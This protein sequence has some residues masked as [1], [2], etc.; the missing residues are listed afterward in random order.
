MSVQTEITRINNEVTGQADLIAQIQTALE[1]KAAGGGMET[2]TITI[3]YTSSSS[4]STR[5]IA[6]LEDGTMYYG[7]E[8]VSANEEVCLTVPKPCLVYINAVRSISGDFED[9]NTGST[10]FINGDVFIDGYYFDAVDP[11]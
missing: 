9:L 11:T 1:G 3:Y 5:L 6:V 7:E 8:D 4:T 2:C 10:F